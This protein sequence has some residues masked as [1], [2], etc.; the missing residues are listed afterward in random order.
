VQGLTAGFTQDHKEYLKGE[1]V[2]RDDGNRVVGVSSS[3][4]QVSLEIG[5]GSGDFNESTPY[6]VTAPQADY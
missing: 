2:I 6:G 3:G 5:D 4:S 1:I